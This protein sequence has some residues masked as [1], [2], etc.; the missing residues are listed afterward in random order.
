M[1]RELKQNLGLPG[2]SSHRNG[3]ETE[4]KIGGVSIPERSG[5]SIAVIASNGSFGT[6]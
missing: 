5:D 1:L 4:E 6:S 2:S 3:T